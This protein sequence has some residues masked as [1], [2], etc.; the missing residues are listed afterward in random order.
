M[1]DYDIYILLNS[2]IILFVRATVKL[3][4]SVVLQSKTVLKDCI[5][6]F[7]Q[8]K[9]LLAAKA[10]SDDACHKICDGDVILVYSRYCS[11]LC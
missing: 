4:F 10:I 8:E 6:S 5:D 3:L 2:E 7:I 9:I 11:V 1:I